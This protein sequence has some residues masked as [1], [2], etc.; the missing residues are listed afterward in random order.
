MPVDKVDGYTNQCGTSEPNGA[1]I[2]ITFKFQYT[3]NGGTCPNDVTGK[4]K[5][6]FYGNGTGSNVNNNIS[7]TVIPKTLWNNF[8]SIAKEL[9]WGL[10]A[11]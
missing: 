6:M 9:L 1:P 2:N 11:K 10:S 5:Y 3:C 4:I 8:E 7:G